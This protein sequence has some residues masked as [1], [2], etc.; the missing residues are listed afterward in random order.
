VGLGLTTKAQRHKDDV[1]RDGQ[2]KVSLPLN[3]AEI[4]SALFIR[5]RSLGDTVLFTPT[6]ENF[7]RAC[8]EARLSVVVDQASAS[9]LIGNPDIDEII[10]S[11]SGNR[12]DRFLRFA[13]KLM[14]GRFDLAVDFHGGPRGAVAAFLSKARYRVGWQ[15]SGHSFVYNIR[16]P[17]AR[18]ILK[19]TSVI[20]TVAKNLAHLL[21]IGVPI[22]STATRVFVG[23]EERRSLDAKLRAAGIDGERP[24]LLVHVG[25]TKKRKE[26]PAER[27][28]RVLISYVKEGG[29]QPV[30]LGSTDDLA[31]WGLISE[32]LPEDARER[33]IS[34]VGK[35]SIPEVKALCE[36]ARVFVGPDSG[37]MH[38][39]DAL[40]TACVALFGKTE[41]RL[42]HPWQSTHI[43]LRPC[44]EIECKTSCP[45]YRTRQ[46]CLNLISEDEIV[47]SI[48]ELE[49]L[50]LA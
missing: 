2:V 14:R 38:I 24:I 31:R 18:K 44:A 33:L 15:Q 6:I 5:I 4:N 43:V 46:G 41:L 10:V 13:Q 29:M 9:L 3:L 21:M 23:P 37:L 8:P 48:L 42:W 27:L 25:A 39:A 19:T 32:L 49:A 7:R 34:L 36:R 12:P 40:G 35:V 22:V 20:H 45:H 17:R 26:Y 11:P 28:A 30:M 16:V 1:L 47:K 50:C